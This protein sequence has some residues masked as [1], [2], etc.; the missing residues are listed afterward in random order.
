[1]DLFCKGNTF[2]TTLEVKYVINGILVIVKDEKSLIISR[3]VTIS[4]IEM[5]E[6]VETSVLENTPNLRPTL[7]KTIKILVRIIIKQRFQIR[8]GLKVNLQGIED[9]IQVKNA[10]KRLRLTYKPTKANYERIHKEQREL[11]MAKMQ[12]LEPNDAKI[13]IPHI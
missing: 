2:H 11:R 7:L 1:M 12:R 5:E 9:I 10:N 6:V 8:K 4:Y 3:N 13:D